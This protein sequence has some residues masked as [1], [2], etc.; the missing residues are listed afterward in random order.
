MNPLSMPM[1]IGLMVFI[2]IAI[3]L[4]AGMPVAD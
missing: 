4:M 1:I 2:G 3:W